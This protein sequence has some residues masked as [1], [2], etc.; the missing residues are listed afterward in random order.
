MAGIWQ[1]G[2]GSEVLFRKYVDATQ[3]EPKVMYAYHDQ[4]AEDNLIFRYD[5][6]AYRPALP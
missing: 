3:A 2:D 5:N 1:F 6:A 4:N